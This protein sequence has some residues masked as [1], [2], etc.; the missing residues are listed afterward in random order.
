MPLWPKFPEVPKDCQMQRIVHWLSASSH[1]AAQFVMGVHCFCSAGQ[2]HLERV[3]QLYCQPREPSIGCL[4]FLQYFDQTAAGGY[5]LPVLLKVESPHL[6]YLPAG[7]QQH[8][9]TIHFEGD[10]G[11]MPPRDVLPAVHHHHHHAQ[12]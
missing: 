4:T 3:F 10:L 11:K 5:L 1:L 2:L 12:G 6:A 9:S 7:R 8:C